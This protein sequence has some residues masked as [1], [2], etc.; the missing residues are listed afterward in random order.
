MKKVIQQINIKT[1][2]DSFHK[3]DN[4]SNINNIKYIS[5]GIAFKI[6]DK[7]YL[8]KNLDKYPRLKEA[9]I[10]HEKAHTDSFK[11]KDIKL[12]LNGK[13]L[14][15]VKKDYYK[16]LFTEKKA[17]YQLLPILKVDGKWS[18]DLIML[19]LWLL[20]LLILVIV[21]EVIK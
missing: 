18:W 6:K 7:I 20:F 19:G 5:Y 21:S 12:D 14:K 17:W 16:F 13:F 4:I 2:Q 9:I 8:N 11:L 1:I 10:K 3:K 15:N